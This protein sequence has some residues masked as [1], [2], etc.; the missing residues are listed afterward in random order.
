MWPLFF[1]VIGCTD[2]STQAPPPKDSA[3]P[4]PD[5][6]PDGAWPDPPA[7]WTQAN[8]L[9]S[10][11]IRYFASTPSRPEE[12]WAGSSIGG[13][14]RSN[15]GGESWTFLA[16]EAPPHAEGDLLI[17]PSRPGGVYYSGG[18]AIYAEGDHTV[19]LSLGSSI[20]EER[21]RAFTFAA[22]GALL[23]INAAA[24]LYQSFDQGI[25][26]ER[27]STLPIG[28]DTQPDVPEPPM[29]SYSA[30]ELEESFWSLGTTLSGAV[31]A[32]RH[33][34]A[35][36]RSYDLDTWE[37][38]HSGPAYVTAFA[39]AGQELWLAV[40]SE[41]YR[42]TD[43]GATWALSL[44]FPEDVV[45]LDLSAD[46]EPL[47]ATSTAAKLGMAGAL[48]PVG[49]HGIMSVGFTGDGI[50]LVGD[51][52]GI[53][54][55]ED[56]GASWIPSDANLEADDPAVLG[57]HPTCPG[58]LITGTWCTRGL[59]RS[60]DGGRTNHHELETRAHYVMVATAN[61]DRIEDQWVTSDE[62]LWYSSNFGVDWEDRA[63]GPLHLHALAIHPDNPDYVLIGS[64]GSGED[65]DDSGR[66]YW[67]D[68][69]GRSWA[70][71]AGLPTTTGSAHALAFWPDDPDSVLLAT[72]RG[73]IFHTEGDGIGLFRSEDAGKSWVP[74]PG[75][76]EPNLRM[77]RICN[78]A[79]AVGESEVY[80]STDRGETWVPVLA[81]DWLALACHGDRVVVAG[82]AD[83][84]RSE[85]GGESW[86]DWSTGFGEIRRDTGFGE[87]QFTRDGRL[88]YLARTTDGTWYRGW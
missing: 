15:D 36:Y 25:S 10:G 23:A 42:S 53:Y 8:P 20:Y 63:P 18:P 35:V 77:L 69:A 44:V 37:E 57:L 17:D 30:R 4:V 67:S 50:P 58:L 1:A 54:R 26:W 6:C 72:H 71:A 24:E 80:R 73:G 84:R 51:R 60:T 68:D 9:K 49:G 13:L 14:L 82:L 19:T 27:R 22:S 40:G 33:G 52:E 81:G 55:S 39:V 70:P 28:G 86:E 62:S 61:E 3:T 83:A 43:D 41:V 65:P 74:V 5:A 38:V 87:L 48:V 46:G 56:V 88:V 76:P 21:V 64:V 2:P 66:V 7:A 11:D 59:Y 45:A 75:M 12:V 32:A 85:D 79:W 29:D 34:G 16:P 31:I 78:D 47:F